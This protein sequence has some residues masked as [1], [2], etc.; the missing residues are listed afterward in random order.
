VF[1]RKVTETG[2]T[3]ETGALEY[4]ELRG[5]KFYRFERDD[6]QV[7]TSTSTART[8]AASCCARPST[9]LA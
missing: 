1:D 9:E 7:S 8:S 5:V 4:A 6:G 2:R 3:I